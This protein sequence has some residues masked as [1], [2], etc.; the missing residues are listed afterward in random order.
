M[1]DFLQNNED[2][3]RGS[4]SG[5]EWNKIGNCGTA[6]L[7]VCFF[8]PFTFVNMFEIFYNICLKYKY[9]STQA[10]FSPENWQVLFKN[11]KSWG[12]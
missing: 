6:Y 2:W 5:Y 7:V 1:S 4:G 11:L 3:V 10:E 12:K 9:W 8:I